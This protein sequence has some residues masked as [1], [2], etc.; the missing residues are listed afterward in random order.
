MKVEAFISGGYKQQYQYKSFTPSTINQEWGWDDPRINTLLEKATQEISELNAFSLIVPNI[1]LFITMHITKEANTSSRI[2]G[3]QTNIDE[4]VGDQDQVPPEKR[5]DWREVQNY[6]RAMN[7][8]LSDLKEFPLSNR[9]IRKTH[10]TL[11]QSVRGEN[12]TPGE[13]R[14]TQNWIGGTNLSNAV[15]IP[16]HHEDVPALMGDLEL[17]LHNENIHVPHLIRIAIAHYQFETIHPFL[18]GNGRIGRLMIT[19]YLVSQQFLHQPSFYVSDYLER[20]R[21]AYYDALTVVR[22][23]NDLGHWIRFFLTAMIETAQRGKRTF[24]EILKLRA[25]TDHLISVMGRRAAN[26]RILIDHLYQHPVITVN[27]AAEILKITHQ[28]ANSLIAELEDQNILIEKTGQ[29]RNRIYVFERYL[30][31]FRD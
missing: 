2:E 4:V 8:A 18:D 17:F 24:Q 29:T 3:T 9:L 26:V 30:E 31:L 11:M 23:S 21:G 20:N 25:E 15:F 19:L 5:D 1:D 6:I 27:R 28:S 12:K 16:P 7:E 10:A 22:S 14:V 13:F